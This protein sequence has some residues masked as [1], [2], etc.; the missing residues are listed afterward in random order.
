[1]VDKRNVSRTLQSDT[2]QSTAVATPSRLRPEDGKI[3]RRISI[4][5]TRSSWYRMCSSK[6][7]FAR[8]T[9]I[10]VRKERETGGP[11]SCT[12]LTSAMT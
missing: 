10:T 9:S 7:V 8:P 1:M 2:V 12:C 5:Y 11:T 3:K 6:D 4:V